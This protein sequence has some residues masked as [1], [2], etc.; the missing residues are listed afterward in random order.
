MK[1]WRL[2]DKYGSSLDLQY[3]FTNCPQKTLVIALKEK[4]NTVFCAVVS[5]ER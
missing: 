5:L 1:D 4:H 3:P 2:V